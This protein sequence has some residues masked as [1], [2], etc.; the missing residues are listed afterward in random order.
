[1]SLGAM[2]ADMRDKP[3]GAMERGRGGPFEARWGPSQ[4]CALPLHAQPRRS[5]ARA[6]EAG[7]RGEVK[8]EHTRLHCRVEQGQM[9][10]THPYVLR[11]IPTWHN[12]PQHGSAWLLQVP[13]CSK[14]PS[15]AQHSTKHLHR[16]LGHCV[17]P[18]LTSPGTADMASPCTNMS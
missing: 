17:C 13:R 5:G 11:C 7:R 4:T 6:E 2:A 16:D 12:V 1:M 18:T 9:P 14:H 8:G 15:T 3:S 10:Q